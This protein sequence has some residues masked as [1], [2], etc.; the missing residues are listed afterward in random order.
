MSGTVSEIRIS[1]VTT[2]GIDLDVVLLQG[3]DDQVANNPLVL[4][5][6]I[7]MKTPTSTT[8]IAILLVTLAIN[9]CT[10]SE[11]PP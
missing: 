5:E 9:A 8:F 6:R 4:A 3:G 1:R 11:P 2:S 7:P 10:T